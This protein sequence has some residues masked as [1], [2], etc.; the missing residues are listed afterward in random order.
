MYCFV[1]WRQCLIKHAQLIE[2]VQHRATKYILNDYISDY[3]SRLIK[4]QILSLA[5]ILE[6]NDNIF[7]SQSQTF[8]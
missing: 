3:K 1:I 6:L 7:H 8:S 2:H 4:L 5:Y